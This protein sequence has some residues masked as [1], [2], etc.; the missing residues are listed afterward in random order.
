MDE[1]G[2]ARAVAGAEAAAE[3]L[4]KVILYAHGM[5]ATDVHMS[6]GMV[7]DVVVGGRMYA[8]DDAPPITAEHIAAWVLLCCPHTHAQLRG[9]DGA[10]D[11]AVTLGDLRVRCAFRRQQGGL[12]LTAR[13]LPLRPTPLH[14]LDVPGH[15]VDLIHRPAG[16]VI[17]SGPTGAGKSTLLAALVDEVNRNQ[18]RHVLTIEEPVEFLHP[19]GRSRISQREVGTDVASFSAALRAA[20]RAR[21]DIV[22]VG[23]MRDA[24]TA[25]AALE[26]ATKG[27]LVLTT[28]HASSATDAL[29]GLVALFPGDEQAAAAGRLAS[30]LQAVIVQRLVPDVTGTK[31][32]PVRELLLHTAGIAAHV[33]SMSFSQIYNA[34]VHSEEGP[35]MFRLEDDLAMKV[36]EKRISVET[37]MQVA[38]HRRQLR[39][40]LDRTARRGG[41]Q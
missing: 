38:N 39:D 40:L 21:P 31:V 2:E 32:V 26:A 8:M 27:Q 13:I 15:I 9:P 5:G 36:A 16:L 18:A 41:Q 28:S 4:G 37:A 17:V 35:G 24:E 20:L 6:A 7:P 19:Q 3:L 22:V 12:A 25:R 29:E 11:G 30:V 33:R 14:E 23:E 10:C 1:A 34:L